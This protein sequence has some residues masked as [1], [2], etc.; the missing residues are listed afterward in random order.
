MRT[1]LWAMRMILRIALLLL[2]KGIA[3][4]G[5]GRNQLL[6][7]EMAHGAQQNLWWLAARFRAIASG[8]CD[9]TEL[10]ELKSLRIL[11]VTLDSKL[12]FETHLRKVVSKAIRSLGIVR[13]AGE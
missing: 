1:V 2:N 3:E 11:G 8:Y 7:F 12:T 9:V 13:R 5:F 6:V 4:S 10:E